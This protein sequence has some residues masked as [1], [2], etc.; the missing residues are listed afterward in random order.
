M[1]YS[2]LE[3]WEIYTGVWQTS[4]E[5]LTWVSKVLDVC[6]WTVLLGCKFLDVSYEVDIREDIYNLFSSFMCNLY[7]QLL[8]QFICT[9]K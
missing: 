4:T 2:H 9:G 6:G 7:E 3:V 1:N 5:Q 8:F